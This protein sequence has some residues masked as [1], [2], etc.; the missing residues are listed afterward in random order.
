MDRSNTVD[1]Y[2]DML[3]NVGVHNAITIESDEHELYLGVGPGNHE[4]ASDLI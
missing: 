2:F 1:S 3:W 4:F